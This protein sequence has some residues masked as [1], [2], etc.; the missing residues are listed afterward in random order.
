M[1]SDRAERNKMILHLLGDDAT[2]LDGL[3]G[4]NPLTSKVALVRAAMEDGAD[5]DYHFV[6]VSPARGIDDTVPCGN[7]LAG[8]APFAIEVGIVKASDPVTKLKIRDK[9][10]GTIVSVELQTPGGELAYDG[11]E[12]IPGTQTPGA[13]VI[14]EYSNIS[15]CRTGKL[16]PTGLRSDRVKG[17]PVTL[18]D[19]AIPVVICPAESVGLP[20]NP[21]I[22]TLHMRTIIDMLLEM[23]EVVA[24][25]AGI[26]TNGST[27]PKVAVVQ[28]STADSDIS[29]RYFTPHTPHTSL[30]VTGAISIA[31]ASLL[32]GTVP[33]E[34]SK[35]TAQPK[36]G[37]RI[38]YRL[39]H[40]AGIMPVDIEFSVDDN[41]ELYPD[42][43]SLVRTARMLMRGKAY[44]PSS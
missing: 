6:Q 38:T 42:K 44:L 13:K 40:V 34:F 31:A 28:E 14:L 1:P 11:D 26:D 41:N 16:W 21:K 36:P 17:V 37:E 19:G 35:V 39:D 8:V 12:I 15:G 23:R 10:L 3:G 27:V 7:I 43:V 18:V 9:N 5:I 30:A 25:K 29:V 33:H 24:A 22:R 4:G 20:E 2:Q 32:D